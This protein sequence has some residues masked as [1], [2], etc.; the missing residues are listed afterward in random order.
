M[1]EPLWQSLRAQAF[2]NAWA[3]HRL[4]QSCATLPV[5]ELTAPKQNFFPTLMATLNHILIVDW[6]YVSALEGACMPPEQAFAAD[7]PCPELPDLCREQHAID[8]RFIKVFDGAPD[9][10]K[11]VTLIRGSG[12]VTEQFHRV[13]LHLIQ[14]QIHHRGQVHA[15]LSGCG[16]APPQL[17]EFYLAWDADRDLRAPDF[18]ALSFNENAV[19]GDD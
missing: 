1:T 4:A 15:M 18:A 5:G 14:H 13:A 19:W 12:P 11:D 2:N 10:T 3:N 16:I 8:R 7:I 9:T 17:D 6:Y